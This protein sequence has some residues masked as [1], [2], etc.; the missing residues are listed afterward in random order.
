M[1]KRGNFR[2]V[3]AILTLTF[4]AGAV[5]QHDPIHFDPEN[6]AHWYRKAFESLTPFDYGA[7]GKYFFSKKGLIEPNSDT[8][9]IEKRF[10]NSTQLRKYLKGEIELNNEIEKH[11]KDKK[12]T[13]DLFIKASKCKFCDWGYGNLENLSQKEGLQYISEQSMLSDGL[14]LVLVDS[15]ISAETGMPDQAIEQLSSAFIINRH[16]FDSS[17]AYGLWDRDIIRCAQHL[18]PLLADHPAA[19]DKLKNSLEDFI[20]NR[21]SCEARFDECT[22]EYMKIIISQ[23]DDIAKSSESQGI[24]FTGTFDINR[25]REYRQELRQAWILPYQEAHPEIEQIRKKFSTLPDS[26]PVDINSYVI[27]LYDRNIV[28]NRYADTYCRTTDNAIYVASVIYLY[29]AKNGTLPSKLPLGMPNDLYS[30]K[31]F[32]YIK[33]EDGF[34]LECQ[35]EDLRHEIFH[36]FDFKF[37][38]S[39][40]S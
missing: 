33:T 11:V 12:N 25:Y 20:A 35:G 40:L 5:A 29:H 6:A 18:L 2:T 22:E 9:E 23:K 31:P 16:C 8:K 21:P 7:T 14:V 19:L 28:Q 34:K 17:L 4:S 24:V 39:K 3:I 27:S 10:E 36:E 38:K 37:P 26:S 15:L 1:N 13:I 30:E 32:L